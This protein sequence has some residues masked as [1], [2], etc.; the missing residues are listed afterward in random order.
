[1][2]SKNTYSILLQAE[3]KGRAIFEHSI[4]ALVVLCTAFSGWQFVSSS[5]VTPGMTAKASAP[6][7]LESTPAPMVAKTAPR[8]PAVADR[9]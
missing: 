9:G 5:V 2:K 7:N 3:E 6:A 4:Y 1:M 8:N